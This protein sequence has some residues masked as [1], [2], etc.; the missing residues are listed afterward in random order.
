MRTAIFPAD[1]SSLDEIRDFV[2]QAADE[3]GFDSR[4]VYAIQLAADEACS[5][6]IE[7]AYQDTPDGK[8]ECTCSLTDAD[9][10]IILRDHGLPFDLDSVPSPDLS[11]DLEKRKVGGLGVYLMRKLMDEVTFEC[12]PEFGNVL[13]MKK[14]REKADE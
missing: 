6:I 7:H 11:P 12:S 1:F 3:A 9:L 13:T 2:G 14:H 8:I 4:S 10:V 5:N